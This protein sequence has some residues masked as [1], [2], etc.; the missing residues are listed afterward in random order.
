MSQ[1]LNIIQTI[2]NLGA[3]VMLPIVIILLGLLFKM[4]LG[5]AI[6]S[7][8]MIGIGF[9]GLSLIVNLL[10]T[11]VQ[12]AINYYKSMGA[13]FTT[14]DM[15]W[16]AIGGASWSVP[17]AAIS[18]PL[19]V[20]FNILLLKLKM[21]KVMN[22]D[23]W[24]YIHFLIPG[25]MAYALFGNAFLGLA[26]TVGLSIITLF[27]SEKIA[28]KWQEYFGLEGT[29][30]TT[31]SFISG[32]YPFT[33]LINKLIDHI[34]WLNKVDVNMEKIGD[35]LGFVGNPAVIGLIVGLLLGLIT[36][37]NWATCLIMGMGV[38][39][40][41]ILL[42][43][44][45]SVMMEGLTALGNHA[46]AYMKKSMGED[47]KIYIGMDIALS[48]GDPACITTTVICIPI[49]ILMAFIIPHMSFFPVGLLTTICYIVPFC[50][51]SSKGNLVR[52]L[53]SSICV[54]F[55][56]EFFANYFAP[57]ATAML[58]VT[59][60]KVAGTVTDGFFGFNPACIIIGFLSKIF[61]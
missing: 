8:L 55:V 60:V 24:N 36:K 1:L 33:F 19:I 3:V 2:L 40:V 42:P 47:S 46:N 30:C 12:P 22:V 58:S 18:I 35:K 15:G 41:L 13:G 38:A 16:A 20:L 49:A 50:A 44:M 61:H 10:I 39:S 28:P 25:A 52:T 26:I 21:T 17:F 14:L 57:Q 5:T 45:V 56:T 43:K 7:G 27:I 11:A 6:K 53:I 48:L 51:L 9:Q 59:G 54:L 32:A 23:I 31:F 37:Q 34:P 29:T 4:K